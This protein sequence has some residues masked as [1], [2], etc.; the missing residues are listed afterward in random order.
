MAL[1][2]F[3][4]SDPQI[5]SAIGCHT[6]LKGGA[7]SLDKVVFVADKIRWDQE[8]RPP[9]L[10]CLESALER[11]LDDAAFCYVSYLWQ[12]RQELPIMHPWLEAAYREFSALSERTS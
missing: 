11:S 9:Y 12:R 3:G 1:N 5:L 2:I 8:G 10:T 4:I 7:S 6:T